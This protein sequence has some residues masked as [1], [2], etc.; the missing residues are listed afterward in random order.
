MALGISQNNAQMLSLT[1]VNGRPV[2]ISPTSMMNI[3]ENE[4]Q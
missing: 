2:A 1:T 3:N 4:S